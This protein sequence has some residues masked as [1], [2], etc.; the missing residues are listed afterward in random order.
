[1]N[2]KYLKHISTLFIVV[3]MSLIMA[4]IAHAKNHGFTGGCQTHIF[5]AWF[6]MLPVAYVS[7]FLIIPPARRFAEKVCHKHEPLA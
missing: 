5:N 3:P 4:F 7:A 1:M 2:K 6:L